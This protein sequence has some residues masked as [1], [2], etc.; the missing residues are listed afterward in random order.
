MERFPL[1]EDCV[2]AIQEAL[3]EAGSEVLSQEPAHAGATP[4][5]YVFEQRDAEIRSAGAWARGVLEDRP[6]AKVAIIVQGLEQ[7]SGRDLRLLRDGFAPGWQ[8]GPASMRD[9]VN[10]S[11]GK[12]LSEYPAISVALL[13]LRWMVRDLSSSEVSMLLQSTL[14]GGGERAG[15]ARLEL[16]LR[17][18]PDRAWAP[19]MVTAALRGREEAADAGDWLARLA[20]FSKRRRELPTHESPGQWALLMDET[21]AGVGWPGPGAQ[22]SDSY[23]LVNRWRELLNEYARLEIVSSRMS[24]QEAVRRLELMAAETLFQPESRQALVQ[25][26]GPLEAAGAEF[27]AVWICGLTAHNWPPAGNP[28]PLVSRHLQREHG[29]PDAT[30]DDTREFAAATLQRL[31]G[32]ASQ[33]VC[34]YALVEDDVEQTVSDL[35]GPVTP[36]RQDSDPGWHAVGLA[37]SADRQFAEDVVPPVAS[38]RIYGGAGTIQRQ[39]SEPFAAFAYGRLA[40]RPLE[41]QA[42]GVPASL[43]GQLVHDALYRL[44]QDLPSAAALRDCDDATLR[45]NVASAVEGAL[46]R[47]ERNSDSVLIR[48]LTL[49][50]E[51]LEKLLEAFVRLDRERGDFEVAAVEGELEFRHGPLSLKLR[52]DRIDRLPDGGVAIIDYKTGKAKKLLKRDGSVDEAQLFVY[53]AACDEPVLALALANIDTRE[54]GFSGAGRGY[55]DEDEWPQLLSDI[56][57]EISRACDELIAG[58]VRI[59][60]RQGAASARRLNLLSRYTELRDDA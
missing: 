37:G 26:M 2:L 35:L 38:E 4:S 20:A 14:I 54:T 32:A 49:E 39:L 59:I 23:Q 40:V 12:R 18:L 27:D 48:L 43:R 24:A 22:S 55:S 16:Q 17:Q 30:P 11:Y 13:V 21:L 44:Y 57:Q 6:D 3:R 9:S 29:M 5:V 1:T 56:G 45:G 50:R 41:R 46:R 42:L 25:L 33:V 36:S 31:V 28:T 19:S 15:R 52:F 47:H 51:R 53:A 34:S 10:V 58:D 8:Y 7:S 60:E